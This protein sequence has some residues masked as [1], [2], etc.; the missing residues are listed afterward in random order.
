MLRKTFIFVFLILIAGICRTSYGETVFTQPCPGG[1]NIT[2]DSSGFSYDPMSGAY[3]ILF[4][5]NNCIS[6]DGTKYNGT[7]YS[8]GTFVFTSETT[9]DVNINVS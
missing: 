2:V 7:V 9:A 5:A 4:Q 3:S 1:G 6:E 8:S